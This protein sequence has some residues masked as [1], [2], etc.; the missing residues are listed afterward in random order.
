[1]NALEAPTD[2]AIEAYTG[3]AA[4]SRGRAYARQGAVF[5]TRRTGETLRA[6]CRGSRA[7]AYAVE[8]T[9]DGG[10]VR[11]AEC[12]CPIGSEGGCKH[13]AALLL[14]WRDRPAEF[15]EAQPLDSALAERDRAELIALIRQMIALQPELESLLDAPLPGTGRQATAADAEAYRRQAI[16][17]FERAGDEWGA[18]SVV[19]HGLKPL[20]GIAAGFA[21]QGDPASASVVYE[22]ILGEVMDRYETVNQE[23]EL[24]ESVA[25]SV[26]GLVSCLGALGT[27]ERAQREA[28]VHALFTAFVFDLETGGMGV[29][30]GVEEALAASATAAERALVTDLAWTALTEAQ[31]AQGEWYRR[32]YGELIEA[33]ATEPLD[34]QAYL[35]LCRQSSRSEALVERLLSLGRLDE[36]VVAAEAVNDYP[37]IALADLFL[38][39]N[40]ER[41]ALRLVQARAERSEDPRLLDWLKQR[42]LRRGDQP[43]ALALAQ[44]LIRRQPSL[45]GY[46]EARALAQSLGRWPALRAPLLEAVQEPYLLCQIFLDEGEIDG[47][48]AL[49]HPSLRMSLPAADPD[50]TRNMADAVTRALGGAQLA[51]AH[52]GVGGEMARRVA[53]AAAQTRPRAA[54]S[55]YQGLIE[56]A[57][58]RRVRQSYAEAAAL[59]LKMGELAERSGAEEEWLNFIATIRLQY[60]RLRALQEELTA[61]GL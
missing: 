26:Q 36:A 14:T 33:L 50:V 51:W 59:L 52:L 38:E 6:R 15:R 27:E 55:V 3:S 21:A 60:P 13:V 54:L 53:E 35:A 46:R 4:L 1:M 41:A 20:L 29:A 30:D 58:G 8:A 31:S 37:L 24:G 25:A 34:D 19:A 61:A 18:E 12:S 2:A 47:A 22:A 28:V 49:L 23:G 43:A 9:L 7:E 32:A 42:A 39:H 40:Q 44:L 11:S 57:I 5:T 10:W 48:L 45:E 17:V 16:A 56:A